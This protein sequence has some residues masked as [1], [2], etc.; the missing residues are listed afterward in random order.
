MF[1]LLVKYNLSMTSVETSRP[2][3]IIILVIVMVNT[4]LIFVVYLFCVFLRTLLDKIFS[5]LI[6]KNIEFFFHNGLEKYHQV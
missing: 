5:L 2:I 1:I 4:E 3:F 6:R